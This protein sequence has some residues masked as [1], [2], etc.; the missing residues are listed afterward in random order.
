MRQPPRRWHLD[1]AEMVRAY[2]RLHERGH[3]HSIEVWDGAELVGGLYGVQVG[4]LFAAESMFHR[5]TNASKLA[6]IASVLKLGEAGVELYDVQFLT[7][8][9]ESLGAYLLHR[10]DY[11]A[12]LA[13]VRGHA[14]D[15][16]RLELGSPAALLLPAVD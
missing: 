5:R 6:L 8:H 9:L 10:T 7:E 4:G 13:A 3:A 2:A 16:G 14:V 12:R 1:F 15:L 11:L